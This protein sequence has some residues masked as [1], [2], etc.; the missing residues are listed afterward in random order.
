MDLIFIQNKYRYHFLSACFTVADHDTEY[1]VLRI[2]AAWKQKTGWGDRRRGNAVSKPPSPLEAFHETVCSGW[3]HGRWDTLQSHMLPVA[4]YLH[5]WIFLPCT[6][7]YVLWARAMCSD[8]TAGCGGC[9]REKEM[10]L[11][12]WN[13]KKY[14]F[15]WAEKVFGCAVSFN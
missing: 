14:I 1:R 9:R 7:K 10:A 4:E 2:K 3:S 11:W 8:D 12:L 6:D 13:V 15:K 5:S